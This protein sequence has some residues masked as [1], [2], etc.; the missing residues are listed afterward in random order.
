MSHARL[1]GRPLGPRRDLLTAHLLRAFR[2][3]G[4]TRGN[5]IV[6]R[7]QAS[8]LRVG[9]LHGS[10]PLAACNDDMEDEEDADTI[11][12]TDRIDNLTRE[13][14]RPPGDT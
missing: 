7:G 6:P 1:P 13:E 12:M 8:D 10:L 11:D 14:Q 5:I 3:D 9:G 4:R 2:A